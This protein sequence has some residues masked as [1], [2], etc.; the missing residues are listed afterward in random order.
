VCAAAAAAAAGFVGVDDG[1]RK[2]KGV[3]EKVKMRKGEDTQR[4]LWGRETKE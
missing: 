1:K 3:G 4:A 2:K